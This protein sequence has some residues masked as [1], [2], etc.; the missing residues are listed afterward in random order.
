MVSLADVRLMLG[1]A[2]ARHSEALG[3]MERQHR[4]DMAMLAQ[5]MT[6]RLD[7]A[8][9]RSEALLERALAPWW[10]RWFW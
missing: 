8:E 4:H 3:A 6:E 9:C 10:R 2:S 5:L 1:E 7:A